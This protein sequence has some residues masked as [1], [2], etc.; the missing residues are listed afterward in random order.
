MSDTVTEL[1]DQ[2]QAQLGF[3]PN[4]Y[5]EMAQA[6]ALLLTYVEGYRHFRAES[7][8]SLAEQEVIFLTVSRFNNCTYC[9]AAH[10]RVALTTSH[11]PEDVVT[12]IRDDQPLPPGRFNAI[13]AVLRE[14]LNRHGNLTPEIRATAAE[15]G[16]ETKD[17]LMLILA[18]SMKT[19]SNW[20]NHIVHSQVDA[21]SA[22]HV[23]TPPEVGSSPVQTP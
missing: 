14:L 16:L 17:L 22:K 10:T 5:K 3:V 13:N 23:W 8:F 2:V 6:P 18:I 12:A 9:M 4:M 19:M 7:G 20:T 11:V 15:A 1:L 21:A